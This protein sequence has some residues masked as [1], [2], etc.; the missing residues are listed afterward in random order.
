LAVGQS[1]TTAARRG[2]AGLA[3]RL[4]VAIPG[5]LG[6][7]GERAGVARDPAEHQAEL[8]VRGRRL[9]GGDSKALGFGPDAKAAGPPAQAAD[10]GKAS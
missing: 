2:R 8:A 9:S 4:A 6:R 3:E 10:G 7:N 1:V 5:R